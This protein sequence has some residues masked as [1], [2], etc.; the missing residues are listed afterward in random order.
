MSCEAKIGDFDVVPVV[1]TLQQHVFWL[2]I[3]MHD[4]LL[5]AEAKCVEECA[6]HV[7]SLAF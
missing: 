7:L 4:A 2:Q 6:N 3:A 5:M 1:G